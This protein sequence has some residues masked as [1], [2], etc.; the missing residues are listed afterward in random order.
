[1]ASPPGSDWIWNPYNV[2]NIVLVPETTSCYVGNLPG[3]TGPCLTLLPPQSRS[4][5][6]QILDDLG[7]KNP[8]SE[9]TGNALRELAQNLQCPLH[10]ESVVGL[11]V[12]MWKDRIVDYMP[13]YYAIQ[14]LLAM[15][16][17]LM[18]S[19]RECSGM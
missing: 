8:L 16:G 19:S 14:E 9:G 11:L 17:G 3:Q 15:K 10:D 12:Q 1:M 6:C 4:S 7:R 2:L 13:E 18:N 5:A